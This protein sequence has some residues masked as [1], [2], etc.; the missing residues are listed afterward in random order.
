MRAFP[1]LV[2]AFAAVLL[3]LPASAE[4]QFEEPADPQYDDDEYAQGASEAAEGGGILDLPVWR[5]FTARIQRHVDADGLLRARRWSNIV[6]GLLLGVT[7][8][9]A[10]AVSAF[11][12]KLSNVVLSLYVTGFGGLLAG[13]ELGIA[14]IAPWVA[15]NLSYLTTGNGRTALLVFAG[16]L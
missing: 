3:V 9:V 4:T 12:L 7:G 2:V 13:L 16:N 6:N 1:L 11:G 10:L 15:K 8:P 14:P 5:E